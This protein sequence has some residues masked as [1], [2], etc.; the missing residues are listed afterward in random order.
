MPYSRTLKN[1]SSADNKIDLSIL[2]INNYAELGRKYEYLQFDQ[3]KHCF[4][5]NSENKDFKLPPK[6]IISIIGSPI[7]IYIENNFKSSTMHLTSQFNYA[8]EMLIKN[9][10]E[11][12]I[13]SEKIGQY[14]MKKM[15][16]ED[17]IKCVPSELQ[18]EVILILNLKD[19]KASDRLKK[20]VKK[21]PFSRFIDSLK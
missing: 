13:N 8:F 15:K 14:F 4:F 11:T 2:S 5:I 21:L 19:K 10:A 18:D 16:V 7:N 17:R 1:L 3:V 9:R 20:E 12:F 6:S